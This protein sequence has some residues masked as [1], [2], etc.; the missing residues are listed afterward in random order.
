MNDK[1]GELSKRIEDSI[2]ILEASIGD[3]DIDPAKKTTLETYKSAL[4]DLKLDTIKE[5][6]QL[7]DSIL[8]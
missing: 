7:R 3:P 4:E 1:I 6:T 5:V 8:A 2:L